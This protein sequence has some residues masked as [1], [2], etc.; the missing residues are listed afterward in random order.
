MTKKQYYLLKNNQKKVKKRRNIVYFLGT[1]KERKYLHLSYGLE[2]DVYEIVVR[3][4]FKR[5]ILG[6]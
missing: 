2:R 4:F 5:R 1:V 6:G 3:Y